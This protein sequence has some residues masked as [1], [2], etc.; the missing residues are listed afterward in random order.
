LARATLEGVGYRMRTIFEPMEEV[1][2]AAHEIRAAGGFIRS[3]L[4]LQIVSDILGRPLR[5]V[6]SPEASALGAAQLAMRGAGIVK[7]FEDLAPMVSPAATVEPD[8]ARHALH[9][10]LYEIYQRLYAAAVPEFT[11]IARLQAELSRNST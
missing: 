7:R 8:R 11:T 3:P 5:L 2:G 10:R 9:S 6:E 4:W 1:A